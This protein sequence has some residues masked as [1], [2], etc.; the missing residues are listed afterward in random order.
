MCLCR[1]GSGFKGHG[2][3]LIQMEI[4]NT[5]SK[6][7]RT[8]HAGIWRF[9]G[10]GKTKGKDP[11]MV[12]GEAMRARLEGWGS[13]KEARKAGVGRVSGRQWDL[14]GRSYW[15]CMRWGSPSP[16]IRQGTQ[17]FFSGGAIW[18]DFGLK[19]LRFVCNQVGVWLQLLTILRWILFER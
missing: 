2:Q 10:R 5:D 18:S 9:P 19:K 17:V 13:S 3:G 16:G 11:E 14:K 7:W 6:E 15:A 8:N 4:L 12:S 1:V